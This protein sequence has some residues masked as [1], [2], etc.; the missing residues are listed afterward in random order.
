MDVTKAVEIK[1]K[2]RSPSLLL[3]LKELTQFV[4]TAATRQRG[5]PDMDLASLEVGAI[6]QDPF[7]PTHL[8]VPNPYDGRRWRRSCPRS[9]AQSCAPLAR[10]VDDRGY[11]GHNQSRFSAPR[12]RMARGNHHIKSLQ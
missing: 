2:R 7:A 11:C 10:V 12:A 4:R 6:S 3:R 5:I 9:K 1:R 8:R